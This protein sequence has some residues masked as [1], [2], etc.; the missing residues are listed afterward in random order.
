[1]RHFASVVH[2]MDLT[3]PTGPISGL[4]GLARPFSQVS[5]VDHCAF[6][7]L[8]MEVSCG[9]AVAMVSVGV[10]ICQDLSSMLLSCPP[11]LLA[12]TASLAQSRVDFNR[13]QHT[14]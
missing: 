3:E 2:C 4:G 1:M 7:G 9:A 14:A 12:P 6:A 11:Q 10:D 8:A 13:P 5:L